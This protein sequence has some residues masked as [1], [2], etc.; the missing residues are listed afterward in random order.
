[1]EPLD[2]IRITHEIDRHLLEL[3]AAV[4]DE[5]LKK[6]LALFHTRWREL[7]YR[8]TADLCGLESNGDAVAPRRR[9]RR[10]RTDAGDATAAIGD[11]DEGAAS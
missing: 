8:V 1:M 10:R 3:S 11:R 2:L 4:T 7:G 9:G 6:D 5:D